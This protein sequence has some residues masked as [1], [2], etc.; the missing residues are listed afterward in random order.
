[1]KL[2]TVVTP[3]YNRRDLLKNVYGSLLAQTCGDFVWMV[4]DDGSEDGTE[5][6]VRSYID[7]GKIEIIYIKKENGGKH[8]ALNR[9]FAETKTELIVIGLDS[10]DVF[11]PDAVEKIVSL[12]N[13]CGGKYNGYIF[14]KEGMVSRIDP[15]LEV[16]PWQDAV[17]EELF[18]GETVHVLKSSYAA[19]FRFPEIEGEKFCTEGYVWL[20]MTEPFRWSRECICSGEYLDDGYSKNII[21]LFA[22]SPRSYMMVSN[23]RLSVWKKFSKRLKFA[24]FYDGFAMM[25]HEKGFVRK[26]SAKLLSALVLPAGF[27]FYLLLKIKG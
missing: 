16:K 2:M 20:Q 10:D 23:L 17:T 5:E 25:A 11:T 21:K 6:L 8:T 15:S 13:E 24:V 22:S 3:T 4:V 1:M 12:Y 14:F 19:K 9:A 7:E 18:K 27:A 26:C